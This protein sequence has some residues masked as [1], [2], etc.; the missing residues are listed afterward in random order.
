MDRLLVAYSLIALLA[1]AAALGLA[2]TIY[3]GRDRTSRRR[4]RRERAARNAKL[5]Q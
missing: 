3:H 4:M 5:H 2:F 1:V